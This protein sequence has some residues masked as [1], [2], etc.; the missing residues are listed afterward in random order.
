MFYTARGTCFHQ[1]SPTFPCNRVLHV[2]RA[3]LVLWFEEVDGILPENLSHV[4]RR[5]LQGTI[6]VQREQRD[7]GGVSPSSCVVGG[8]HDLYGVTAS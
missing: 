2:H 5:C 4:S 7:G 3:S 6:V 8:R 1:E